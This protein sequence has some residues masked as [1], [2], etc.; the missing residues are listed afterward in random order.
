MKKVGEIH[1][2]DNDDDDAITKTTKSRKLI[3][4]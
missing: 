2:I 1:K 3:D 4:V